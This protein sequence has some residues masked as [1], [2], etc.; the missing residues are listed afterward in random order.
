MTGGS[1]V[2]VLINRHGSVN[3][4]SNSSLSSCKWIARMLL[5]PLEFIY[6]SSRKLFNKGLEKLKEHKS[7][8]ENSVTTN[9]LS[10]RV[11]CSFSMKRLFI[12]QDRFLLTFSWFNKWLIGIYGLIQNTLYFFQLWSNK[13]DPCTPTR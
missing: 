5:K 6:T 13:W 9:Y 2:K 10:V 4:I 11:S 7:K 8:T 12:W 3:S 1:K